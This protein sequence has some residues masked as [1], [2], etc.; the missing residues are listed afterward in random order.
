MEILHVWA[1][2]PEALNVAIQLRIEEQKGW[3]EVASELTAR[4]GDMFTYDAVV[5]KLRKHFGKK[6]KPKATK[7]NKKEIMLLPDVHCPFMHPLMKETILQHAKKEMTLII[8]GDFFDLY[9]CSYFTKDQHIPL[10]EE[11]V[12]GHELLLWLSDLFSEIIIIPGNHEERLERMIQERIDPSVSFLL[13]SS[14]LSYFTRGFEAPNSKYYCAIPNLKVHNNW[15]V[16]YGDAII[17]HPKSYSKIHGRIAIDA[18]TY[19]KNWGHS[20]RAVFVAHTHQYARIVSNGLLAMEIGCNC[21][22][23][24]YAQTGKLGYKPQTNAVTIVVQYD[25]QTDFNE[26]RSI[27]Y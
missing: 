9:S 25:G 7:A 20:F 2:H 8:P 18:A 21:S 16:D 17:A 6:H 14:F 1:K 26:T 22:E 3:S 12:S 23:Q 13:N 15:F 19:F 11:M 10:H 4:F 27:L 24:G 5:S